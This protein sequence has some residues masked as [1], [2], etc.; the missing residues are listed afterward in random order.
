MLGESLTLL[1]CVLLFQHRFHY[2]VSGKLL[3]RF[4]IQGE[5]HTV[6]PIAVRK[7]VDVYTVSRDSEQEAAPRACS[8]SSHRHSTLLLSFVASLLGK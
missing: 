7:N 4:L 5:Y 1:F 8:G 2:P 3:E 6:S